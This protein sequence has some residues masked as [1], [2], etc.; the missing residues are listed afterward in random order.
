MASDDVNLKSV[1]A[2]FARLIAEQNALRAAIM[3]RFDQQ[4]KE[5]SEI[6]VQAKLT[7]GRVN[8]LEY[9]ERERRVRYATSAAIF[10][11]IGA[12]LAWAADY[13]FKH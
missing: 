13:L 2:M 5:L 1:D 9:V 12:G 4:D 3:G 10:S 8:K 6:K 7:N 11:G